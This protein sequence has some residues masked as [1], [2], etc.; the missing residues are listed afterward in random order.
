MGSDPASRLSRDRRNPQQS[1]W[2]ALGGHASGT[3]TPTR[4]DYRRLRLSRGMTYRMPS[5]DVNLGGGKSVI[6]GNNR[7]K[8][9]KRS[10][11]LRPSRRS[12]AGNTSLRRTSAPTSD[13]D[14][15]NMETN[16]V[17]GLAGKPAIHHLSRARRFRD[18]GLSQERWGSDDL[19][20]KTLHPGLRQRRAVSRE[21]AL[22]AGAKLVVTD[23]EPARA[24]AVASETGATS[25]SPMQSMMSR[26]TFSPLR[27]RGIINDD[28]I[29]AE[30]RDRR[31]RRTT[32]ARG[33]SWQRARKARNSVCTDYGCKCRRRDHVYREVPD[34]TRACAEE[35]TRFMIHCWVI[36][37]REV[38]ENAFVRKQQT[39]G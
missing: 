18:P 3:M 27:A 20:N 11:V 19:A 23:I 14:S 21:G 37:N 26:P 2:T 28:T 24:N 15:C 16:H 10:F 22:D 25:L 30:G 29:R 1:A 9:A 34:G 38:G 31:W 35:A 4:K 36:R 6:I 17:A 39:G 7:T 13:M 5:R 33:T 32:A 12:L 8:I